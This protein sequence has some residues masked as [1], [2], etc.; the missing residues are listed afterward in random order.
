M[1]RGTLVAPLLEGVGAERTVGL[2][3]ALEPLEQALRV[4][5]VF[6]CFTLLVWDRPPGPCSGPSALGA[7]VVGDGVADVALLDVCEEPL[8]VLDPDLDSVLN[9]VQ[10]EHVL[11]RNLQTSVFSLR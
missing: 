6:A 3:A 2:A 5:L 8:D 1:H 7:V 4:E 9:S 11:N 10:F